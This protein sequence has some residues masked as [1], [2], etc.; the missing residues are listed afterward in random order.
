MEKYGFVYIWYDRKHKRYYVGSHWGLEDDGYVC[1][2]NWMRDAFRNRPHDFKRRVIKRVFTDRKLLLLEEQK[3]LNMINK[4]EIKKGNKSKYYNLSLSVKNPWFNDE[5]KNQTVRQKLKNWWTEERRLEVGKRM[6]GDKN[7]MKNKSVVEKV[8]EKNR[9][10]IP[11]N[12]GIPQSEEQKSKH[13]KFMK[14]RPSPNKGKK[15]SEAQKKKI[16]EFNKDRI[17]YCNPS[18]NKMIHI[19]DTEIVP[20]GFVRGRLGST[21]SEEVKQRIS[22]NMKGKKKTKISCPYCKK[23]GGLPQMKRWHFENCREII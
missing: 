22:D 21:H 4:N 13:S 7:P 23:E 14:G 9:G 12:K 18:I 5:T 1:S 6:L 20:D 17:W 16:S 10:K 11:W 15:L 2:S 3:Y 19:K 8:A